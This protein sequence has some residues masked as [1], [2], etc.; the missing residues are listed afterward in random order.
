[1]TSSVG[2][3]SV[4]LCVWCALIALTTNTC[5]CMSVLFFVMPVGMCTCN[6]SHA[7]TDLLKQNWMTQKTVGNQ[8]LMLIR[9]HHGQNAASPCSNTTFYHG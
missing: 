5:V 8:K 3:C 1:M 9:F 7:C 4:L 6:C 2:V